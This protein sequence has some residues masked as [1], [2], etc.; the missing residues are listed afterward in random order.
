MNG[1]IDVITAERVARV[2]SLQ[3]RAEFL[4]GEMEIKAVNSELARPKRFAL[5]S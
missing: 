4:G 2:V 1:N 5:A 3:K